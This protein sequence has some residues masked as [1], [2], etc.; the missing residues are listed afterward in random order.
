MCVCMSPGV[1]GARRLVRIHSAHSFCFK[2]NTR[3]PYLVVMEV[4]GCMD[5]ENPALRVS[6]S[7]GRS[8][9][10]AALR[11][12]GKQLGKMMGRVRVKRKAARGVELS[13][14]RPPVSV[15]EGE[16]GY[17]AVSDEGSPVRHK[18]AMGQWDSPTAARRCV[19]LCPCVSVRVGVCVCMCVCLSLCHCVSE[20]V[21][22]GTAR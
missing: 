6:G 18:A 14:T 5:R 21:H 19:C 16:G 2:T 10:A 8:G 12:K 22:A 11:T 9:V 15:G 7:P 3:V 13:V 17:V 1:C 4:V 20:S